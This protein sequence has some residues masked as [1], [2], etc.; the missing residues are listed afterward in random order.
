MSIPSEIRGQ[1]YISLATFRKNGQPVLT[2]VWFGEVNDKLYVMTSSR[3]GK[4]K[5]VRNNSKVKI[6][7]CTARGKVTGPEFSGVARI[8][9]LQDGPA[10]RKAINR[11]Y[12]MARM[13]IWWR[14]DTYFE[15]DITP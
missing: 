14:T 11:I 1:K 2:P 5:R 13:P 6:A 3:L 10:A 8:L 9:P 15:I 4:V 12:F 7:P